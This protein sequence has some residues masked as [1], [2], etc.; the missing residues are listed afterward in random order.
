MTYATFRDTFQTK[1]QLIGDGL[2][3]YGQKQF[4]YLEKA[5]LGVC[6]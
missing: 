5:D 2:S 4:P 3:N 6:G 1:Y